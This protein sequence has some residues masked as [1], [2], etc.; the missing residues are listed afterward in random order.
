MDINDPNVMDLSHLK[1]TQEDRFKIH[2]KMGLPVN[3]LRRVLDTLYDGE[4][5]T[6][7]WLTQI[8]AFYSKKQNLTREHQVYLWLIRNEL[9]GLRLVEFFENEDGFLNAM[10]L[11]INRIEGRKISL[12]RIKIDEAL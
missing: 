9:T 10:N 2:Q 3:E 4:M 11:I 1:A 7:I 5:R 6:A 8:R 12:E